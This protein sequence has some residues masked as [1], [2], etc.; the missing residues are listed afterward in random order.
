MRGVVA[1]DANGIPSMLAFCLMD[2]DRGDA[3][4]CNERLMGAGSQFLRIEDC[5]IIIPVT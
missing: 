4:K 5:F 2:R 3:A 1:K